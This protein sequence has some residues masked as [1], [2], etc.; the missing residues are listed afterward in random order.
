MKYIALAVAL[1]LLGC[2][3]QA[4]AGTDATAAATN[5][6]LSPGIS[7]VRIGD[8]GAGF[9]ACG[10]RGM[11]VNLSRGGVAYLPLRAAPFAEAQ[12]IA[13]LGNGAALFLCTRS[14]DQKWQGVVVPPEAAP[15]TDCGVSAPVAAPTTYAGPCRAGWVAN[16]FVQISPR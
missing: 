10:T 15:D 16:D 12:E 5:Q 1:L 7:P 3:R 4:P 8:A 9:A 6:I 14:I 13:R 11:V 2:G